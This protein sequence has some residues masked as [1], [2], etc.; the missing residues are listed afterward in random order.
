MSKIVRA[1]AK[2]ESFIEDGD[3]ETLKAF[4]EEDRKSVV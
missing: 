3:F 2:G 1:V 4:I